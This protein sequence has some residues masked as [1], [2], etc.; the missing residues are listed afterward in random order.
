ME[1]YLKLCNGLYGKRT[2]KKKNRYKKK[3]DKKK[4][5]RYMYMWVSLVA[6]W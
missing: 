4:K 2:F 6:Q 1:L 3:K 5:N